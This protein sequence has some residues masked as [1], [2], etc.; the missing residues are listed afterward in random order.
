MNGNIP[1]SSVYVIT[2]SSYKA[3]FLTPILLL[4]GLAIYTIVLMFFAKWYFTKNQQRTTTPTPQPSNQRMVSE[5]SLPFGLAVL[6]NPLVYQWRGSVEGELTKKDEASIT[7]TKNGK[8]IIIP[9]DSKLTPFFIIPEDKKAKKMKSAT[10]VDIPIGV[11][12]RGEFFTTPKPTDKN[13][14]FGSMFEVTTKAP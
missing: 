6:Q 13:S 11:Y 14:I 2:D 8:T 3:K 12:L 5:D 10:I 9:V 4:L 1:D 7:L